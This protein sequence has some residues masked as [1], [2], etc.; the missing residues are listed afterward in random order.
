MSPTNVEVINDILHY[1]ANYNVS[2]LTVVTNGY[3]LC[4]L[5]VLNFKEFSGS[6]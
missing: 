6:G 3:V 4:Q 1:L 5:A 2:K